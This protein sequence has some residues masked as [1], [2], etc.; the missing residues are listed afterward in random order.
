[1]FEHYDQHDLLGN[2]LTL[3]ETSSRTKELKIKARGPRPLCALDW[4]I[5]PKFGQAPH[6]D[7][8]E[9]GPI[10]CEM[11]ISAG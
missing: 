7:A 1:M 6:I 9:K 8:D 10:D 4:Q 5:S 11:K 2:P 3:T